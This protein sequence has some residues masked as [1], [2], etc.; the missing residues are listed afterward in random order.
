MARGAPIPVPSVMPLVRAMLV[1]LALLIAGATSDAVADAPVPSSRER[2]LDAR[3]FVGPPIPF[4]LAKWRFGRVEEPAPG[5]PQVFGSYAKGCMT[6]AVEL[7]ADGDHW[8]AMRLSR[9]RRWGH[10]DVIR[11]VEA[12][13]ADAP[14][15]G[16]RGVLVG[17]I[18]Q[19]RGGPMPFGHSSHQ[20]GLDVDIW[21][22]E[23]PAERL[24]ETARETLP[25]TSMLNAAGDNIDPDLFTVPFAKLVRRA[26]QDRRVQRMFVHPII[27]RSLCN[28]EAGDRRWLRKVRPWY[29]HHKHFHVRLSCPEGSRGC[30]GQ[31]PPPAGDGCG[32]PLDYWFTAAPYTPKP[33]AK[34]PQPM[35]MADLPPVC[36]RLVGG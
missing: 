10:P 12:L 4:H 33:G 25:F 18:S 13:A 22:T 29:G 1:V 3:T 24:S 8:Q 9:D 26:A 21:F 2:A 36:R 31:R 17:D 14:A 28:W 15:L 6:G 7:A 19:P 20:V 32:A 23:M 30:R 5:P 16:L 34:P 35:T 27:K 11:F